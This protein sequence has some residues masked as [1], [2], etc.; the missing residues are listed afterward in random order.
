MI[1]QHYFP[2]LKPTQIYAYTGHVYTIAE[3]VWRLDIAWFMMLRF[4]FLC[5]R[6]HWTNL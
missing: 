3:M 4:M 2:N 5:S 6:K 1:L